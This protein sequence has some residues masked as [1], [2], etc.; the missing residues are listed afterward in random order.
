MTESITEAKNNNPDV[1]EGKKF[2][3]VYI[4]AAV[5]LGMNHTKCLFPVCHLFPFIKKE[6]ATGNIPLCGGL[7]VNLSHLKRQARNNRGI[8]FYTWVCVWVCAV[9]LQLFPFT[10]F[11]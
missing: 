4:S 10:F 6:E 5:Q 3:Y 2:G 7:F 1:C 11:L 8:V 9:Y